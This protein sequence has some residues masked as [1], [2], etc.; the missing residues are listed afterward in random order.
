MKKLMSAL[1]TAA[2][3]AMLASGCATSAP[4]TAEPSSADTS[5]PADPGVGAITDLPDLKGKKL[6]VQTDT[7]GQ[8]Y[9]EEN[10]AA[11]GYEVVVFDD[12]PGCANAVLAGTAD[13]CINDNGVLFDYATQNPTTKVVKEFA[14]GEE[15]GMNVGKDNTALHEFV[16]ATLAEFKADGTYNTIF[17]KWFGTD[18]GAT[19]TS[20]GYP[21]PAAAAG[22]L[23][24]SGTLTMCTHMAYRPF[25]YYDTDNTTIIGFDVDLAEALAGKLGASLAIVDIEFGQITSGAVFTAKKCDIGVAATTIT[26][27]RKQGSLF[28]DGYFDATQA[29]LVKA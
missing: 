15:Y 8:I 2:A 12:L 23:I 14:T 28:S 18:P 13:A 20:A 22:T 5:A 29:L 11:N 4:S 19:G 3:L 9:A 25:E 17:Q 27:E 16:N 6:A 7:T 24:K 10:Q 21:D 1:A 26:D